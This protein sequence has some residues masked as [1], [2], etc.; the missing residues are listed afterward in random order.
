MQLI[1]ALAKETQQFVVPTHAEHR[2]FRPI[3]YLGS[4]LRLTQQ[5]RTLVEQVSGR[6]ST[7]HRRF[8]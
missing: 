7:V 4:K 8:A 6:D 5:I 1:F 3:Q 2:P